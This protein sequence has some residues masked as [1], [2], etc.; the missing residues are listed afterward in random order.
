MFTYTAYLKPFLKDITICNLYSY[1]ELEN[2]N[3]KS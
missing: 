2:S 3:I 1:T